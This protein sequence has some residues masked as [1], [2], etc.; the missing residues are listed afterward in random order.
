MDKL[1]TALQEATAEEKAA[2]VAA[3]SELRAMQGV[4][5]VATGSGPAS[6]WRSTPPDQEGFYWLKRRDESLTVVKITRSLLCYSTHGHAGSKR[7]SLQGLW[8][9]PLT[10]PSADPNSVIRPYPIAL[11][12]GCS[13]GARRGTSGGSAT[14]NFH[15]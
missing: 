14:S 8:A 5:A 10:P 4:A 15:G 2:S 13:C 3:S 6:Q 1:T 11:L 7:G 12:A 9:G